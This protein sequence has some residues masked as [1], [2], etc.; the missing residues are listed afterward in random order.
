MSG[1]QRYE[2]G[3]DRWTRR[4]IEER[5]MDM[6]NGVQYKERVTYSETRKGNVRV[7]SVQQV[8]FKKGDGQKTI[9]Y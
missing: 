6:G 3:R 7:K 5:R 1:L 8:D 4:E 2:G 9:K